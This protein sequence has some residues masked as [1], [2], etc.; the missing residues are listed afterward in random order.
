MR[1]PAVAGLFYPQDAEALARAI[2]GFLAKAHETPL[3]DIRALV[4]PHAGYEYSGA[5]AAFSYRQV[6]GRDIK[7]VFI[8][9]PSHYASFRGAFIPAVGAYRTPLGVVRLSPRAA[10]LAAR[11]PFSSRPLC[12]VSRPDW[13]RH[14]PQAVPRDGVDMP[15][16]W[17]HSGE[18]QV[19]FLQRVLKDFQI[20]PVVFGEV[21]PAEVARAIEPLLDDK[22]LIVASSDLSH[23][24]PYDDACRLDKSCLDAV[25]ALDPQKAQGQEACGIGPILTLMHIARDQGWQAKR[26]DYRN[27]GDTA[28]DKGRVVGYGAVAFCGPLRPSGAASAAF[29]ASQRKW[30]LKLARKALTEAVRNGKPPTVDPT[31]LAACLTENKGCFVTLTEGGRLRGCIGHILPQEPLYKAIMDNARSAALEDP[32]FRPVQPEEL[33]KIEIEISVLT[34]PQPLAFKDPQDLMDRLQPEKDGVVLKVGDRGATY[35]PQVWEQIPD[36]AQFLDSLSVK[37]GCPAGAWR[38]GPTA[39]FTYHVEAWKEK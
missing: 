27:S 31:T 16:T 10:E 5:T 38:T 18:V 25:C 11:A 23:Y 4:C 20:V 26:L 8:L 2:D 9:S 15:D 37:A 33:D 21:D 7:T 3:E 34:S 14:S 39:V 13:W 32:R 19:P 29:D 12:V 28:G 35:L 24:H 22:T 17:E 6:A 30:L 1:E 36:K